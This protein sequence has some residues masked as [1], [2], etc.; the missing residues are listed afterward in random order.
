MASAYGSN[1]NMEHE[2]IMIDTRYADVVNAAVY[3]QKDYIFLM[4][5]T[6]HK[7][8]KH[9]LWLRLMGLAETWWM[10]K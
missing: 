8:V 1:G 4:S 2:S 9:L 6:I 3:R 5:F 10:I 7:E